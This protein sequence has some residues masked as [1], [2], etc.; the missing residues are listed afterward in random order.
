MSPVQLESRALRVL[1]AVRAGRAFEDSYVELKAEFPADPAKAARRI[2]AH[3]N[4]AHGAPILWLIGV[5]QNKGVVGTEHTELSKWLPAVI[6]CFDGVYPSVRDLVIRF[7]Q[8]HVLALQFQTDRA[9]YLVSTGLG[10]V[11]REVPWREGTLTRTARREELLMMLQPDIPLPQFEILEAE[12]AP[13][14]PGNDASQ[15]RC[16]MTVYTVP[17]GSDRVAIPFH[18]CWGKIICDG[19]IV[20]ERLPLRCWTHRTGSLSL[21]T[22]R[23]SGAPVV[24]VRGAAEPVEVVD[25]QLLLARPARVHVFF[26]ATLP[27]NSLPIQT[28]TIEISLGL[29]GSSRVCV[30]SA[31]LANRVL[32][33]SG[34]FAWQLE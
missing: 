18:R 5:D 24:N 6:A 4:S 8:K 10:G 34:L 16:T 33:K 2:A 21:V 31:V 14:E 29:A 32:A 30:L 22:R 3:A 27:S 20:A 7:D 11:Q 17:S 25:D 12:I 23:P 26:A 1:D 19:R 9:P 13:A 28:P 15:L